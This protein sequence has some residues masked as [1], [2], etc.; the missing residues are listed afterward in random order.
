[1]HLNGSRSVQDVTHNTTTQPQARWM[2][3][4]QSDSGQRAQQIPIVGSLALGRDAQCDIVIESQSISSFHARIEEELGK[5]WIQDLNSTNGTLVNGQ[6][7]KNRFCLNDGDKVRCANSVFI[8]KET[9]RDPGQTIEKTIRSIQFERLFNG[10]FLPF[11]QP[12]MDIGD[13]PNTVMGLEM[14]G[15][16]RVIG[17]RTPQEMFS[18]AS[19]LDLEIELS[20]S[21]MQQ[22]FE[23]SDQH[24]P[25]EIKLFF[26]TQPRE[27]RDDRLLN[28]LEALRNNHPHR[29]LTI[30][31]SAKAL[32]D[33]DTL[34]RFG[35]RLQDLNIKLAIHNFGST[36][37]RLFAL[38]DIHPHY[39]K[40]DEN[41][42]RNIE[43][44]SLEHQRFVYALVKFIKELGIKAVAERVETEGEH[45]TLRQMGFGL[46][47]GLFYGGPK[48]L[49]ACIS[50][51]EQIP[52]VKSER[53]NHAEPVTVTP[54]TSRSVNA[55]HTAGLIDYHSE[56]W[57]MQQRPES[58]TV[59]VQ[60]A[61][62]LKRAEAY[63]A[64]QDDKDEFAIF[65]KPNKSRMVYVV[66]CGR[67]RDQ[68]S[69]QAALN[70]L[71]AAAV[72]PLIRAIGD[73]QNEIAGTD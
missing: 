40:F 14:L 69:A 70:K 50:W 68:E 20:S 6:R 34:V 53:P 11:F 23:S 38:R 2:L 33:L 26:N 19:Q 59:Q 47:Q 72:S 58:Y 1:M 35:S 44:Q 49:P 46:A 63:V 24:L 62:S 8:I 30:E 27:L 64:K 3:L 32:E 45:Q 56:D 52:L 28:S 18:T 39:V 67:H 10:G 51:L 37:P 17:L 22:G 12:I 15:R 42:I 66:I 57:I 36:E 41:L 73:I 65:A 21:L 16:S 48:S 60:I 31:I 9:P 13:E 25:P 5:L 54:L 71:P 4:Q 61:T 55:E 7:I 29:G 43:N